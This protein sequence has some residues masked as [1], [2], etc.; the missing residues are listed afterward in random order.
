MS[1]Q[2]DIPVDA[3]MDSSRGWRAGWRRVWREFSLLGRDP[4]IAVG[5]TEIPAAAQAAIA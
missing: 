3:G 2:T 5:L 4:V 1:V